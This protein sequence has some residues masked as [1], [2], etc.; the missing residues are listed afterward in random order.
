MQIG[1][2]IVNAWLILLVVILVI[3]FAAITI[4]WGIRAHKMKIDAGA[5]EM[6][7]RT[8]EVKTALRPK[9]SVF[10]EGELWTAVSESGNV[11][12]G[13]EVVIKKVTGMVLTV[14]KK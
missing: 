13:E 3:A 2:E 6:V 7:G 4:I 11:D 1:G 12:V 10:V 14:A 9:G 5:E 8:A